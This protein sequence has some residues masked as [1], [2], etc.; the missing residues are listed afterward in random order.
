[1]LEFSS[2]VLSTLS[3]YL[4]SLQNSII[5]IYRIINGSM[6][7]KLNLLKATHIFNADN[8]M[9]PL[10]HFKAIIQYKR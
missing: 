7:L 4:K 8:M 6:N 1:M 10:N 3:L 2:T 9:L 5:H